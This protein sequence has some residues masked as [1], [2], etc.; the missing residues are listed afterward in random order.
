MMDAPTQLASDVE[1]DQLDGAVWQR[2][3]E[4]GTHGNCVEVARNLPD[5]VAM[6][7]SK[8][9]DGPKLV[10]TV[11]AWTSLLNTVRQGFSGALD[12]P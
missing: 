3:S 4:S 7:D 6:R 8:D 12:Q 1:V 9:P 2:S 5:L 11:N 10:L